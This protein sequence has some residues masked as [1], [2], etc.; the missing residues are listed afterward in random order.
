MHITPALTGLF[1]TTAGALIGPNDAPAPW[2]ISSLSTFSPSGRPGSSPYSILN[3]TIS[4]PNTILAGPSPTGPAVFPPSTAICNTSFVGTAPPYN[5]I[6][7]CSE[8]QYG[9]WTFEILEANNTSYPSATT[10]FDV[11]FTHVDNVTVI[12][13]VYSQVYAGTGHFEV[14]KNMA[15]IC[16]ASG[17]CSW[18]LKDEERPYL[19]Q[20]SRVSCTGTCS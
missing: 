3:I 19:I 18:G 10:N 6:L 8:V 5:Q 2:E 9:S 20:Q 14:G 4:D 15:G 12:G 11:R 17:V 7:N 16:G 13:D 1:S